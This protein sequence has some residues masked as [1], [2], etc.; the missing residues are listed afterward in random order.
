GPFRNKLGRRIWIDLIP[1]IQNNFKL[2]RAAGGPPFL[3]L[4]IQALIPIGAQFGLGAGSVWFASAQLASAAPSGGYTG[5]RIQS[6]TVF[7]SQPVQP[8][9]SLE[10]IVPLDV[11]CTISLQ[12]DSGTAPAGSGPGEDARQAKVETPKTVTMAFD[13]SGA[14]IQAVDSAHLEVFGS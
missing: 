4:P 7:F 5:L 8:S 11:S 3:I 6:G 10:I 12:L 1:I 9:A 14:T 13:A 2:V